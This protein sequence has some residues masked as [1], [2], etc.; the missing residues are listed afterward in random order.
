MKSQGKCT[1]GEGECNSADFFSSFIITSSFPRDSSLLLLPWERFLVEFSVLRH[2][3]VVPWLSPLCHLLQFYECFSRP[4]LFPASRVG[5]ISLD[6]GE[7]SYLIENSVVIVLCHDNKLTIVNTRL[8]DPLMTVLIQCWTTAKA[9]SDCQCSYQLSFDGFIINNAIDN[10]WP[11]IVAFAII[12][13]YC[14][15][16]FHLSIN[17]DFAQFTSS[18]KR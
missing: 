9:L 17:K 2:R 18:V 12:H 1:A 3:F 11:R 13:H 15:R 6:A 4:K 10:H 8:H 16:L 5:N 14:L 7:K